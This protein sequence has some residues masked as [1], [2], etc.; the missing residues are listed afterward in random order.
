ML[1]LRRVPAVTGTPPSTNVFIAFPDN[2]ICRESNPALGFVAPC[3]AQPTGNC[4]KCNG[5]PVMYGTPGKALEVQIQ[6]GSYTVALVGGS[7][8]WCA[9]DPCGCGDQG[10]TNS[11]AFRYA[12]SGQAYNTSGSGVPACTTAPATLYL[13][14]YGDLPAQNS[15][16]G[17]TVRIT[18]PPLS[19]S[20]PTSTPLNTGTP[21]MA[22]T[23]TPGISATASSTVPCGQSTP[24]A[25]SPSATGPTPQYAA[26]F[27][28]RFEA[29]AVEPNG[30][31]VW[32]SDLDHNWVA[33]FDTVS[34]QFD[35]TINTA[36]TPMG[37]AIDPKGRF[38][39]VT[40][41]T[42]DEITVIG[43]VNSPPVWNRNIDL[44]GGTACGAH[45]LGIAF[46]PDGLSFF[47]A[48]PGLGRVQSF[49]SD[50]S[51]LPQDTAALPSPV[52]VA[53][54]PSGQRVYVSSASPGQGIRA[55]D[56]SL[57]PVLDLHSSNTPASEQYAGIAVSADGSKIYA[58]RTDATHRGI[59]VFSATGAYLKALVTPVALVGKSN[60]APYQLS[61]TTDG[62]F[63]T[64]TF[65]GV[66]D[67]AVYDARF[68]LLLTDP[69]WQPSPFGIASG[70]AGV[71][72]TSSSDGNWAYVVS[73]TNVLT[74]FWLPG[75]VGPTMT[76]TATATLSGTITQTWTVSPTF[77]I[78][79]TPSASGSPTFTGSPTFSS[80][81]SRTAT[82]TFTVSGT[83]TYSFT[84]TATRTATPA[85]ITAPYFDDVNSTPQ[86]DWTA[87]PGWIQVT[88]SAL[89]AA[90][91]S[92]TGAW[93]GTLCASGCA[94]GPCPVVDM[95]GMLISPEVYLPPSIVNPSLR[96]WFSL[97]ARPASGEPGAQCDDSRPRE[98]CS[99]FSDE[100]E[101]LVSVDSGGTFAT[102][103]T[104]TCPQPYQGTS[105]FSLAPYSGSNVRI[106]FIV[107]DANSLPRKLRIC[108]TIDDIL[109]GGSLG[110]TPSET[111][112]ES[113]TESPS[114]TF[115]RT[116]SAT[117]TA[118]PTFPPG[119]TA[120]PTLP[121]TSVVGLG[122][123]WAA[124]A[125]A[126]GNYVYVA[127]RAGRVWTINANTL[128]VYGFEAIGK[129]PGDPIDLAASQAGANLYTAY[130]GGS[131]IAVL[132]RSTPNAPHLT[133][134]IPA[135]PN[136]QRV[137]AAPN[138]DLV[139]SNRGTANAAPFPTFTS[140]T[141][142]R[143]S[144]IGTLIGL[145]SMGVDA[146]ARGIAADPMGRYAFVGSTRPGVNRLMRADTLGG[147]ATP[148]FVSASPV[149]ELAASPDGARVYFK[150]TGG[151]SVGII[152]PFG[153]AS[154]SMTSGIT[155]GR[156]AVAPNNGCLAVT[157]LLGG[158]AVVR[159]FA[160]GSLSPLTSPLVVSGGAGNPGAQGVAFSS[161][162]QRLF[163]CD[164]A[165]GRL[166]VYDLSFLPVPSA[167]QT[168]TAPGTPSPSFTRTVCATKTPTATPSPSM[169]VTSTGTVSAT[170]TPPS[171]Y[172][173]PA[174][175]AAVPSAGHTIFG[176]AAVGVS[177][178][179][180]GGPAPS[181]F[182]ACG[183]H[184]ASPN[185]G[186]LARTQPGSTSWA[187]LGSALS[188]RLVAVSARSEIPVG[189]GPPGLVPVAY[190]AGNNHVYR[191]PGGGAFSSATLPA[192]AGLNATAL[193]VYASVGGGVWVCGNV[194]SS[195]ADFSAS[196]VWRSTTWPT[197]VL[198]FQGATDTALNSIHGRSDSDLWTVGTSGTAYHFDGAAFASATVSP[199][200][201]LRSV[202]VDDSGGAWAVGDGT[203]QDASPASPGA[204]GFWRL[205]GGSF[206]GW[207][208]PIR[209]DPTATPGAGTR[210]FR[211][212][213]SVSATEAWAVGDGGE[214][215]HFVEGSGWSDAHPHGDNGILTTRPLFALAMG[216][217]SVVGGGSP[218]SRIVGWAGGAEDTLLRYVDAAV[219]RIVTTPTFSLTITATPSRTATITLTPT[220][221]PN[222]RAGGDGASGAPPAVF[223][224][225]A[226]V[227][228]V[229]VD[230]VGG[231]RVNRPGVAWAPRCERAGFAAMRESVPLK[232]VRVSKYFRRAS[233]R[234]SATSVCEDGAYI[235]AAT[236]HAYGK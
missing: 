123:P 8:T 36:W 209:I 206:V 28:T 51:W 101:V 151:S 21:S 41:A 130:E 109:I 159:L 26:S 80:T 140:G 191:F 128:Q 157:G 27:A 60:P 97:E 195:A 215:L 61:A 114:I 188:D 82:P 208:G 63:L 235:S 135:G 23:S 229:A 65:S 132:D 202:W 85:S 74:A 182:Y 32:A 78:S 19:T 225:D 228:R 227:D 217:T 91:T 231:G 1:P 22:P 178:I 156:I 150:D 86:A 33:R 52:A 167:T 223:Q 88:A 204:G 47:V 234:A 183:G 108:C 112:T 162:S 163:V 136:A 89:C 104:L 81:F 75:R 120:I 121:F 144:S 84:V 118:T 155:S 34:R 54:A 56:R 127:D 37:L 141:I 87:S 187:A 180:F 96:F 13:W 110:P 9:P 161:N 43:L 30:R 138:G 20:S 14:I 50:P 142:T 38:L 106:A 17:I 92:G 166:V 171:L 222:P 55:L 79:F 31:F 42:A 107:R 71:G 213:Q 186:F 69:P 207:T 181:I 67:V 199:G 158:N 25:V 68:D 115:T 53:V 176:L 46:A 214:I 35:R 173:S 193:G 100:L 66:P 103:S 177:F 232:I 192:P 201:I 148:I 168:F 129:Q 226:N 184:S 95:T 126:D 11:Q 44:C 45:S 200:G 221:S 113:S 76:N 16:G 197:F 64:G 147:T 102:L 170:Q 90:P 125:S 62:R 105:E 175:L 205:T 224:F 160:T 122:T 189:P 216:S 10:P 145:T 143:Y 18:G 149:D 154:A 5:T 70:L 24:T 29:V 152:D 15:G 174:S 59:E 93:L 169:T 194:A 57:V 190:A 172:W 133:G 94:S 218:G 179:P 73:N 164:P 119:P 98:D 111:P 185:D 72:V 58:A 49:L 6:P 219:T 12:V 211:D 134:Y 7:Y 236:R 210:S 165:S 131:S 117:R 116:A 233:T 212:V 198:A 153:G 99:S 146:D 139:V 48:V 124:V 230:L 4:V 220:S 39:Y 137:A 77:T 203:Y 83:T 40:G 196:A 2:T 3:C